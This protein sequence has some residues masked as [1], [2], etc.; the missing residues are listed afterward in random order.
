M[1]WTPTYK[2]L[3]KFNDVRTIKRFVWLPKLVGSTWVWLEYVHVDQQYLGHV[4]GWVDQK[5]NLIRNLTSSEH[6][7]STITTAPKNLTR[8]DTLTRK[9]VFLVR[10]NADIHKKFTQDT[11]RSLDR[12]PNKLKLL[13]E[14]PAVLVLITW[15]KTRTKAELRMVGFTDL[16]LKFLFQEN[17]D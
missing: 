16:P 11:G 12:V 17:S 9:I 1:R 6:L 8:N 7:M 10:D 4:T 14:D 15:L 3:P 2:P 5:F 13:V